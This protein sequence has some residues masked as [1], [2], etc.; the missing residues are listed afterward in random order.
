MINFSLCN[1]VLK[2]CTLIVLIIFVSIGKTNGQ[3]LKYKIKAKNATDIHYSPDN[4]YFFVSSSTSIKQFTYGSQTRVNEFLEPSYNETTIPTSKV[5][6]FS[7]G[8]RTKLAYGGTDKKIKIRELPMGHIIQEFGEFS[9]NIIAL[10]F[11]ENDRYLIGAFEDGTIKNWDLIEKKELYTRKD[12]KRALRTMTVSSDGRYFAV[13]GGDKTIFIYETKTG[14]VVQKISGH[15]NWVRS[16]AFS[17]D[18]ETIASGGDDKKICL[19]DVKSGTKKFDLNQTGW[20][21]DLEFT[22]DGK[23]L[24]A[25][26]E[27]SAIH[28]YAV[29]NG[30]LTHTIE[31]FNAPV[32]RIAISPGGKEIASVEAYSSNVKIWSIESLNIA[33]TMRFKDA[34]DVTSPLI[35][36]ANP[37]NI[38]DNKVIVYQDLIDFRGLVTDDAGVRSVKVMV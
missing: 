7:I 10:G 2:G 23:Y 20:V 6:K 17:P 12:F 4:L 27:K 30:M 37:P 32:V 5:L 24:V 34:S 15:D 19:W 8:G 18:G 25:G 29:S 26:L 11:A 38:I 3:Q 16:V 1:K 31:K 33:P 28:F 13:A 14:S 36:V 21:Y 35:M 9:T 22:Q